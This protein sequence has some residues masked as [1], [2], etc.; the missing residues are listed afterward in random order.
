MGDKS[1]KNSQKLRQQAEA[2]D[3]AKGGAATNAVAQAGSKISQC[4]YGISK[5]Q[6]NTRP[7]NDRKR[8]FGGQQCAGC[9]F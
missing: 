7:C 3:K 6:F 9:P 5:A 4:R 2:R 1:P 8:T